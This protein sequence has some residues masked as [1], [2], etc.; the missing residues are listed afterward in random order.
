MRV[1]VV[2]SIFAATFNLIDEYITGC[3]I[4]ENKQSC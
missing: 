4:G 3:I 1:I 2:I